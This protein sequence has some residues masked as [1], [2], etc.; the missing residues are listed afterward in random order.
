[1]SE[2]CILPPSTPACE[3][4]RN[5]CDVGFYD[6]AAFYYCG[7][8]AGWPMLLGV[9]ALVVILIAVVCVMMLIIVLNYMLVNLEYI[10]RVLL[11][12]QEVML[13]ILVPLGN[14]FPDLILYYIAFN[15]NS[16]DLVVG[17]LLG[18][19]TILFTVVFGLIALVYP[20]TVTQPKL[21]TI[22][23]T[24]V[25]VVIVVFALVLSDGKIT[26]G[27]CWGLTSIYVVYV[28]LVYIFDKNKIEEFQDEMEDLAEGT[29]ELPHYGS[30]PLKPDL[31]TETFTSMEMFVASLDL[32][33]S[34]LIPLVEPLQV[35]S[36]FSI[37]ERFVNSPLHKHW[38]TAMTVIILD[39]EYFEV[40]NPQ[41][42]V[43]IIVAAML[44]VEVCGRWL[45]EKL[46]NI[47]VAMAGVTIPLMIM[48]NILIE[49]LQVLKNLGLIWRILE[50]LLGLLVFSI[51][52]SLNDLITNLSLAYHKPIYGVNACLGTP[53]L[54]ISLGVGLNGL[55]VLYQR[56]QPWFEFHLHNRVVFVSSL[57]VMIMPC[58]YLYLRGNNWR[59]D[60]RL[61][62]ILLVVYF[63]TIAI[64]GVAL[65]T[66]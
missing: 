18:S 25:G 42:I 58:L 53:M 52:N 35:H 55:L 64:E 40:W 66:L 34:V 29:E 30:V 27:E 14:S 28:A 44:V 36:L 63:I 37:K 45:P 1:M 3:Y 7:G 49:I 21:L 59:F 24:A 48:S 6:I 22:D 65:T 47:V 15:S 61:G 9:S 39:Y 26:R 20:F 43:P 10:A 16:P 60:R 56:G 2:Q 17:Q 32:C 31:D 46:N 38:L 41:I 19:L 33:L 5:H 50:F 11:V 8:H 12:N 57:L 54:N 51:S 23:M 62:L 13:F 4:I